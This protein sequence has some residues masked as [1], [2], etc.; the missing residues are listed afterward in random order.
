MKIWVYDFPIRPGLSEFDKLPNPNLAHNM[1][2]DGIFGETI[3]AVRRR[4]VDLLIYTPDELERMYRGPFIG[5]ALKEGI[6]IYES[7]AQSI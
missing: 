2:T 5:R 1:A 7:Q 6:V 4:G 3:D